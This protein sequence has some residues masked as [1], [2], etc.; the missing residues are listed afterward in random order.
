[1]GTRL[2]CL[3]CGNFVVESEPDM[4]LAISCRCGAL[5]PIL[6]TETESLVSI[7][8]SLAMIAEVQGQKAH[9]ERYLGYSDHTSDAKATLRRILLATGLTPMEECGAGRCKDDYARK[10]REVVDGVRPGAE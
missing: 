10:R 2:H 7:P 9:V 4:T 6:V 8:G 1:M 3:G 5:S